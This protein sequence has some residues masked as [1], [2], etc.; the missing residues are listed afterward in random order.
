M[1]SF[2]RSCIKGWRKVEQWSW[3][4]LAAVCRHSTADCQPHCRIVR[5]PPACSAPLLTRHYLFHFCICLALICLSLVVRLGSFSL[6]R[7]PSRVNIH[8]LLQHCFRYIVR[9]PVSGI[10]YTLRNGIFFLQSSPN[11]K[12]PG[13]E[14]VQETLIEAV[15]FHEAFRPICNYLIKAIFWKFQPMIGSLSPSNSSRLVKYK[16]L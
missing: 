5:L 10:Y 12:S 16:W 7:L 9:I 4:H 3:W 13:V 8:Y 14:G 15:K 11:I 6:C 1:S 2:A